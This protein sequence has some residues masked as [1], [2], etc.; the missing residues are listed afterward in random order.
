[1]SEPASPAEIP[2]H[3][4]A[5]PT[6]GPLPRLEPTRPARFVLSNGLEVF[7]VRREVAPLVA[8]NL[9]FRTG[10]DGDDSTTDTDDSGSDSPATN[11]YDDD[12]APASEAPRHALLEP[13]TLLDQRFRIESVLGKGG[14][15]AVY[16]AVDT[17]TGEAVALKTL[18][19]ASES[20]PAL[21]R[22][23]AREA[24]V[25]ARRGRSAK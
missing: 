22:R 13:G 17:A 24:E 25:I 7:A 3:M 6:V 10:S 11:P 12:A 14:M 23:F 9:M 5:A 16:R 2:A 4:T 1:M 8:A 21:R 19:L 20:D 15:G 18:L